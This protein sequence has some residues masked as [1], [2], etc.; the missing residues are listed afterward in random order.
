MPTR[1]EL[2]FFELYS[3]NAEQL[4]TNTIPDREE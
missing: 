1:Q 2:G 4:I 3:L